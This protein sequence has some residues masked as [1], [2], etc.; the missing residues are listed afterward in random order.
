MKKIKKEK[1]IQIKIK[2]KQKECRKLPDNEK[3]ERMI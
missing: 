3:V 2:K 1:V